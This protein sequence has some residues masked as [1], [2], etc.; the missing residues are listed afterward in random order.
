[1]SRWLFKHGIYPESGLGNH[2]FVAQ[3]IADVGISFQPIGQFLPAVFAFALFIKPG[4]V[5]F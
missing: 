1:L 4:V 5:G 3:H 2:F